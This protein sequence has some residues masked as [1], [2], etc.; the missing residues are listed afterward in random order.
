VTATESA[1]Q[2]D[3]GICLRYSYN[4]RTI[5]QPRRAGLSAIAEPCY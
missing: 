3:T 1:L 4:S 5:F 2:A